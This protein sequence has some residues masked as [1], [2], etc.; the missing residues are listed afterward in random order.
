LNGETIKVVIGTVQLAAATI[1]VFEPLQFV[2]SV[3][4][5]DPTLWRI[6]TVYDVM[7]EPPLKGAVH[8]IITPV[9]EIVTVEG[10]AG[11]EGLAAALTSISD[12]KAL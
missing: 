4:N 3:L 6:V 8:W 2:K 11:R 5:V 7:G 9:F 1:A 10:A 12:E